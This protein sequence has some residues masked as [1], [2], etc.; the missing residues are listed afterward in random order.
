MN[1]L[2]W[3]ILLNIL[4]FAPD[5]LRVTEKWVTC[6]A[7]CRHSPLCR[8]QPPKAYRESRMQCT[9]AEWDP[10][11]A[12]AQ[13]LPCAFM[14]FHPLFPNILIDACTMPWP[15]PGAGSTERK[16]YKSGTCA[17]QNKD[18]WEGVVEGTWV[19]ESGWPTSVP[20]LSYLPEVTHNLS[21]YLQ[22]VKW[23]VKG[24]GGELLK[25]LRDE[26]SSGL[27]EGCWA[28]R[29]RGCRWTLFELTSWRSPGPE[30]RHHEHCRVHHVSCLKTKPLGL[31]SDPSLRTAPTGP[32]G[33][34]TPHP[35]KLFTL[36][37]SPTAGCC[38]DPPN[39]LP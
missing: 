3:P 38:S 35:T 30:E 27:G 25:Q 36:A 5:I 12:P 16:S 23:I 10:A 20:W 8:Q 32:V 29:R 28:G 22:S 26:P 9:H 11:P 15:M 24:S 39:N 21:L 33:S 1:K 18:R 6:P 17:N 7:I 4:G 13:K 34:H 31:C 19:L 2:A 14:S 37:Y